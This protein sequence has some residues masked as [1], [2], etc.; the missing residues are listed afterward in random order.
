MGRMFVISGLDERSMS[1]NPLV[2]ICG[3]RNVVWRRNYY[4]VS[5]N[6]LFNNILDEW[7]RHNVNEVGRSGV[8]QVL[9]EEDVPSWTLQAMV[10]LATWPEEKE[11]GRLVT[12][13][14]DHRCFP[15]NLR[16]LHLVFPP[17]KSGKEISR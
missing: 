7:L 3:I 11:S 6:E 10:C 13:S 16:E 4:F 8:V 14:S 9:P 17:G 5:S 2:H 12:N 15:G 1:I